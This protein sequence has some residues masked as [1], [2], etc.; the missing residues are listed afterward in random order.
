MAGNTMRHIQKLL[1]PRLFGFAIF[2]NGAKIVTATDD[3]AQTNGEDIHQWV[4]FS[5]IHSRVNQVT[6]SLTNSGFFH[7]NDT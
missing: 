3:G 4:E 2:F 7:E 5:S 6:K 1:K